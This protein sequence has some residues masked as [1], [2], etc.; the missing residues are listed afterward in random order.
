LGNTKAE[1]KQI[2]HYVYGESYRKYLGS[3]TMSI[4]KSKLVFLM[5]HLD[6]ATVKLKFQNE[7]PMSMSL[8]LKWRT[9]Y[10]MASQI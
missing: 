9:E 1:D 2:H 4:F 8:Q 3:N 7:W 6:F 10:A 5:A